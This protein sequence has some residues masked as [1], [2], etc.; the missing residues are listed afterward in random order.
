MN[1]QSTYAGLA[2]LVA[3]KGRGDDSM[4]V[5]MTPSEIRGLHAIARANGI[6]P[7]VNP[8][9]GLDEMGWLQSLLPAVAGFTLN[10][11]IGRAHV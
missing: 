5:H 2:S 4:L 9:T 1:T 8:H 3:A 11:E 7:T 10:Q 6:T